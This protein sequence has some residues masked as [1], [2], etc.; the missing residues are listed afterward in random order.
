[1]GAFYETIPQSVQSWILEQKMFWVATAPLSGSGHVNVS[2]KGGEYFGLI[3]EKTFW[4][5]ELTGSGCET[6]AH[7]YE[8]GNGRIT[9]MLCAFEGPPKIV[10]L[11]GKGRVLESESPEFNDFVS[12]FNIETIPGTRSIIIVDVHQAGSSCGFSVPVYEFKSQREVLNDYFKAKERKYKQGNEKES[13]DR[14]WALK[15]QFSMD[16]LEAMKRGVEV[17]RREKIQ[18]MKKMVGPRTPRNQYSRSRVRG[19]ALETL[20]LVLVSF[21]MGILIA[22]SASSVVPIIPGLDRLWALPS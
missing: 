6:L 18:P 16:G 19:S 7:L 22:L 12:N 3:D 17:G 11:W 10:R 13:M 1:M 20:A 15:S 14:Y 2:P 8:R 4:Y 9:I 5:M 21:A